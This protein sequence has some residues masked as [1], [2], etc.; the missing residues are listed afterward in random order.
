M[1]IVAPLRCDERS[2]ALLQFHPVS[3]RYYLVAIVNS[4]V[5]PPK[6]PGIP[7]R[8]RPQTMR[9]ADNAGPRDPSV[10]GSAP[11]VVP[12]E[13]AVYCLLR[14]KTFRLGD[15]VEA[16]QGDLLDV[17]VLAAGE[18]GVPT[19]LGRNDVQ[20]TDTPLPAAAAC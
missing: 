7:H 14:R 12:V 19:H 13:A 18:R 8:A 15:A 1:G 3:A 5:L 20:A 6:P 4:R 2:S 17:E 10:V 16:V 11:S 9:G